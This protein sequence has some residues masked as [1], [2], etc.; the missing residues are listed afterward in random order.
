MRDKVIDVFIE[1][2]TEK[3]ALDRCPGFKQ[4]Y[5]EGDTVEADFMVSGIRNYFNTPWPGIPPLSIETLIENM[6]EANVKYAVLH[7]IDMETKTPWYTK[8]EWKP[9]KWQ[10]P[11]DYVKEVLDKCPDRFK[12]IAGVN[13]F[14]PRNVV[15]QEI[16]KYI[17][18]WGFVGIKLIPFAGFL[19]TDKELLYPIYERCV[20]LDAIVVIMSS[21]IGVPGMRGIGAHPLHVDEVA[22]DFPELKI[23]LLHMGERPLWGRDAVAVCFHA[24]NV[25]TCTSPANPQLWTGLAKNPDI[26]RYTADMIPN[27]LMFASNYP[28]AFPIRDAIDAIDQISGVTEEFK[29]KMF[30]ENAARFYGFE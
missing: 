17:K 25:Y 14:K 13:P 15:L 1:L 27:Q 7:G 29:K 23:H 4:Q 16:E 19:P 20:N 22:A 10:C 12:A 28:A 5:W 8:G 9:F 26:L 3:A 21:M 11:A 24:P 6:D 30:Y 18:D 2:G